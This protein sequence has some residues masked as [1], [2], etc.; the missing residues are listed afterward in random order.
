MSTE[1]KTADVRKSKFLFAHIKNYQVY[2]NDE[3]EVGKENETCVE[4][5]E[6]QRQTDRKEGRKMLKIDLDKRCGVQIVVRVFILF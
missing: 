3:I 5:K 4:Q 2:G 1:N 6:K